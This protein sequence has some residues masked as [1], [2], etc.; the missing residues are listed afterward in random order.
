MLVW[1]VQK[2][3][4]DNIFIFCFLFLLSLSLSLSISHHFI[5]VLLLL[6]CAENLHV[7]HIVLWKKRCSKWLVAI[8]KIKVC[9][10]VVL[11]LVASLFSSTCAKMAQITV[12]LWVYY[13]SLSSSS[14]SSLSFS[15]CSQRCVCFHSRENIFL[16]L[17]FNFLYCDCRRLHLRLCHFCIL[18]SYLMYVNAGRIH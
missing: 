12:Q 4:L 3:T 16:F 15:S 13:I 6:S 18:F 1:S 11:V 2:R 5:I 8:P 10:L 17:S 7:K 14:S 9:S